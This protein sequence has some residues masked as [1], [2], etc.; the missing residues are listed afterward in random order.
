M[1]KINR[2]NLKNIRDD[3]DWFW[4]HKEHLLFGKEQRKIKPTTPKYILAGKDVYVEDMTDKQVRQEFSKLICPTPKDIE[5]TTAVIDF[6]IANKIKK[7]EVHYSGSGDSG[8]IDTLDIAE[9]HKELK[10]N[11]HFCDGCNHIREIPIAD[12]IEELCY[13]LLSLEYGGWE[14]NDGS[15]GQFIF[16]GTKITHEHNAHYTDTNTYNHTYGKK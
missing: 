3:N 16:D 10:M 14:I 12:A 9:K 7:W 15:N 4:K 13:H 6:C 8:G 2:L 1:T 5:M 11:M